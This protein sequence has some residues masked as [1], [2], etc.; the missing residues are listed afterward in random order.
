LVAAQVTQA[1]VESDAVDQRRGEKDGE[2]HF[3]NERNR[4]HSDHGGSQ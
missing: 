2:R 1:A 4:K 3:D